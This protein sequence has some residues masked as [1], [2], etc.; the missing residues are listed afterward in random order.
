MYSCVM[1]VGRILRCACTAVLFSL[2]L[3]RGHSSSLCAGPDGG[4]KELG[5]RRLPFIPRSPPQQTDAASI[6]GYTKFDER[7]RQI[8]GLGRLPTSAALV[9]GKGETFVQRQ[10]QSG[11]EGILNSNHHLSHST[12]RLRLPWT[13]FNVRWMRDALSA[14]N[15][16]RLRSSAMIDLEGGGEG[17]KTVGSAVKQVAVRGGATAF[18]EG[19]A[20]ASSWANAVEGLKNGLASGLAAACVKT[21]LQPFDTMKTVQQFSTARYVHWDHRHRGLVGMR[22]ALCD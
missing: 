22:V 1:E 18:A 19:Q 17:W 15:R 6:V 21:V 7:R 10:T 12:T 5:G 14:A 16:V 3:S 20:E 4:R 13:N 11:V 9:V 2:S 8:F